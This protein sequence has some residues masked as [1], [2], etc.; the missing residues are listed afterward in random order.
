MRNDDQVLNDLAAFKVALASKYRNI[1][2]YKSSRIGVQRKMYIKLPMSPVCFRKKF[3]N[4]VPELSSWNGD[5]ISC[6]LKVSD[7][8]SVLG[9]RWHIGQSKACSTQA[10]IIGNVSLKYSCQKIDVQQTSFNG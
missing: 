3:A 4:V 2:R 1:R 8:D 6:K 5:S 9:S 7:L 10:R